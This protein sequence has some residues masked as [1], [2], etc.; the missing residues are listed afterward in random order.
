MTKQN[1]NTEKQCDIHV[2]M[3]RFNLTDKQI[4][5]MADK[6]SDK[7]QHLML[8]NIPNEWILSHAFQLGMKYYRDLANEA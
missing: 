4:E 7:E 8:P 2:V 1:K 5:I 6:F 3:P